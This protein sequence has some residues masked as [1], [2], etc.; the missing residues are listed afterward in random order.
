MKMFTKSLCL[1]SIVLMTYVNFT[2]V[3]AQEGLGDIFYAGT[4]DA[5]TYL[6][7]YLEP[8]FKSFSYGMNSGWYNT[9]KPHKSLGFD[10]T[11]TMNF[12]TV[13]SGEDLFLFQNSD[14]NYMRLQNGTQDEVPTLF[15]P[16]EFGSSIEVYDN[17]NVL[18]VDTTIV[19]TTFDAPQGLGISQYTGGFTAMPAPTLNFGIGIIKGTELKI[20]F[21]PDVSKDVDYT[22]WGIGVLHD[23]GQWIPGLNKLPIDLSVF[24]GYTKLSFTRMFE[25][26]G[27]DGENQGIQYDQTGWTLEALVSKKISVLTIYGGLGY[28]SAK[29]ETNIL[30]TYQVDLPDPGVPGYTP[31]SFTIEDGDVKLDTSGSS[32]RATIGLRL[33]LSVFTIH[34]QYAYNGYNT[35]STGLGL[36]F[37]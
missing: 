36:S 32:V 37:R 35:F 17:V 2:S 24:A 21:I 10:L 16:D 19:L 22:L 31:P 28:N 20:R 15:G 1:L 8:M 11:V 13:P 3:R 6:D 18:G 30:G 26:S 5:T 7:N 25:D 9:A 23:W 12:A 33:K 27:F 4:A 29:T 34:G 14:Y